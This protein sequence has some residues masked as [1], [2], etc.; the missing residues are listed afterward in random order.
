MWLHESID[1]VDLKVNKAIIKAKRSITKS[2]HQ[3]L[4]VKSYINAAGQEAIAAD[5][6]SEKIFLKTLVDEGFSG[7]LYSEESGI[8]YF[9]DPEEGDPASIILLLDP[10]DGSQNYVKS[11]PIGCISVAYGKYKQSPHLNDLTHAAV[12]NL[13]NNELYFSSKGNGA[14]MNAVK[15]PNYND[16]KLPPFRDRDIHI[17]YYAY[18]A[19]A[20]RYSFDFQDIYTL[21][22]LGSAAWE[23]AMV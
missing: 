3:D 1:E 17:S 14:F 21:R 7:T 15:L 12:M 16:L 10:L 8:K 13:Y 11:I 19:N 2:S 6:L 22:S 20:S 23:L 9:G 18:G 5:L 4:T